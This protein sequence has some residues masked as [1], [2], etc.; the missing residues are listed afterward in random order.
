MGLKGMNVER[1][2]NLMADFLFPGN[3]PVCEGPPYRTVDSYMCAECMDVIPWITGVRCNLCG[4]PMSGMEFGGLTCSSCRE[5][6][7]SFRS[8]RCLFMLDRMGKKVVHEIKYHGV[9]CVLKD[10]PHWLERSSGIPEYV[11]DSVLVPVPLHRKRLRTRGF[12]QSL[13]I[14]QALNREIGRG[15]EVSE[16]LKRERNTPSQTKLDRKWRKAN[17]KNAFALEPRTCLDTK[18]PIVLVDD[19]F[20]TGATLDSCAQVLVDM[21]CEDVSVLAL[22]R[23]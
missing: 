7:R 12:N 1:W 2:F 23:G 15:T 18:K 9:R 17:V 3:C 4:I 22:G 16:L 11:E 6:A 14:A 8:G 13:W 5:E 21:G 10:L 20:T 19:V